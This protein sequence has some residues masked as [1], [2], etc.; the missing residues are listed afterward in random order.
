LRKRGFKGHNSHGGAI[1]TM[2]FFGDPVK[3]DEI[4]HVMAYVRSPKK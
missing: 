2:Q 1:G 3:K 4:L